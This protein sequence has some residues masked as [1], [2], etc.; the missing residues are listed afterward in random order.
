MFALQLPWEAATG[1]SLDCG[2]RSCCPRES[3]THIAFAVPVP[4]QFYP[5]KN[6]IAHAFPEVQTSTPSHVLECGCGTGSCV[7]PLMKQYAPSSTSGS[8]VTGGCDLSV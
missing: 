1:S 3:R 5:I 8:C 6:Y 7:L 2:C 4:L